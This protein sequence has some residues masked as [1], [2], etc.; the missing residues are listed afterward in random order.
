[1]NP[2]LHIT[3]LYC[4]PA[5]IIC[6]C[7]LGCENDY[8]AVQALAT[9]K[10]GIDEIKNVESYLSQ[11]GAMRAKLTSPLMLRY[12]TDTP[13]IEFPHT[14]HVD[15]YNDS[16]QVESQIFA[17]YGRFLESERKVY[18][19]DSVVV[20]NINGDTLRTEELWWDQN[21]QTIYTKKEVMIRQPGSDYM[22]GLDGMEA[23]QSLNHWTLFN[24]SAKRTVADSTM[25]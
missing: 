24:A 23:D 21:K 19:R 15:M 18:L 20:F 22:H 13:K 11:G 8:K 16:T 14:L 5:L 9:K 3:R 1:M 4:L 2:F 12:Q 7:L 17:K 10:I 6:F 25:P